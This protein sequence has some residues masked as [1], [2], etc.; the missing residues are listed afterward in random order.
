MKSSIAEPE[1]KNIYRFIWGVLADGFDVD[2]RPFP[3]CEFS[4][5]ANSLEMLIGVA[6]TDTGVTVSL[7][8]GELVNSLPRIFGVT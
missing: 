3:D 5:G 4:A 6:G 1:H 2:T 7:V 8:L